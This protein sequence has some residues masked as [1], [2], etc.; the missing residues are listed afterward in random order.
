VSFALTAAAPWALLITCVA[1]A[2]WLEH[3]LTPLWFTIAVPSTI[4]T[5]SIAT[6]ASAI[7]GAAVS[8]ESNSV[9]ARILGVVL[10]ASVAW[11]L[12]ATARHGGRVRASRRANLP[13]ERATARGSDL[14]VID[15][16]EPDAFAVPT[17]R[18]VVV[19]TVGMCRALDSDELSALICHERAH[20][21]YR[22]SA[23]IQLCEFAARINPIATPVTGSVRHAA[24]RHADEVAASAGRRSLVRALARA[25]LAR[26]AHRRPPGACALHSSGGNVVRRIRALTEPAPPPTPKRAVAA[27][28]LFALVTVAVTAALGDV[29]VDCVFPEPGESATAVFR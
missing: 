10:L 2:P 20:L 26:S 5:L 11:R 7:A 23:W 14:L 19:V 21:R 15:D 4:A 18:G 24:E 8:L 9:P 29:V 16:P 22:H 6:V 13:M 1:I 3:A 25:S 27:L 17:R 12:S 28:A